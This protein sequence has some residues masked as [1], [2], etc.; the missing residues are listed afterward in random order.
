M[1]KQVGHEIWLNRFKEGG[2]ILYDLEFLEDENKRR[3]ATFGYSAGYA[4]AAVA[5]FSWA[6]QILHPGKPQGAIPSLDDKP[7]LINYVKTALE[8]A[9]KANGGK[10]PRVIIIGAQGRCGRGATELCRQTGQEDLLLWDLPETK[11][12]GPFPEITG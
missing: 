8:P 6:H 2:G 4:G 11:K 7:T 5:L 1:Q 12:G 3:V 10:A 9:I